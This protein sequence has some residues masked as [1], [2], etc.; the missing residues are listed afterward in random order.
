MK[1]ELEHIHKF[2]PAMKRTS[3]VHALVD[4]NLCF[5]EGIYGLTGKN[6]AGKSTLLQ[7]ITGFIQPDTGVIRWDGQEVNTRSR[8]YK[9]LLG[10]MPQQQALYEKMTCEQ[11]MEYLAGMKGIAPKARR[12][13]VRGWLDNVHLSDRRSEKI[14]CLSGGMKQ[15]LLFA[16]A[17][18]GNPRIVLLDEP[19]AGVDPEEREHIQELV[20]TYAPG[21]IIVMSTH[22]LT[23]IEHIGA[24]EV[25]MNGGRAAI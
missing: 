15:R 24:Q 9:R 25:K 6:G 1:L 23:D 4:V 12:Q 17:L 7:I 10:Y 11:F 22:I 20:A 19:T 13:E 5:E 3:A 16:Q 21:K 2:Y 8:E 14:E 18:L